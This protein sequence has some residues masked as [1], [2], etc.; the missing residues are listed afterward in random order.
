M[1]FGSHHLGSA[2]PACAPGSRGLE[3]PFEAFL[4]SEDLASARIDSASDGLTTTL[5]VCSSRLL[6]IAR[7][8]IAVM[9]RHSTR[10]APSSGWEARARMSRLAF[11]T[12][13][14]KRVPYS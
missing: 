11:G 14:N 12:C 4:A 9:Y 6:E 13:T 7:A 10:S 5:L 8:Q 2:R 1:Q 3:P